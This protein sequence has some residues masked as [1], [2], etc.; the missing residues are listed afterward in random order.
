MMRWR[1]TDD[2]WK[3]PFSPSGFSS[4]VICFDVLFTLRV[5]YEEC[6]VGVSHHRVQDLI[7]QEYTWEC[8]HPCYCTANDQADFWLRPSDSV[9]TVSLYGLGVRI[10]QAPCSTDRLNPAIPFWILRDHAT[11]KP[12][13]ILYWW[14]SHLPDLVGEMEYIGLRAWMQCPTPFGCVPKFSF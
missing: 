13:P 4:E 8:N 9:Q 5:I 6:R 10:L 7:P 11:Y 14:C 1:G 3:I 12:V 2:F